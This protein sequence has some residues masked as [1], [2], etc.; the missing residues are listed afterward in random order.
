MKHRPIYILFSMF[1]LALAGGVTWVT[2]PFF[3]N[4]AYIIKSGSMQPAIFPGDVVVAQTG[5]DIPYQPHDIVTFT[6]ENN[7]RLFTTHRI[8]NKLV[9]NGITFYQTK[10][11]ANNQKDN[12]LVPEANIVGKVKFTIPFVGHI[13]AFARTKQG[14]PWFVL[15]PSFMVI[16]TES[17]NIVSELKKLKKK[18]IDFEMIGGF[19]QISLNETVQKVLSKTTNHSFQI[20]IPVLAV[21]VILAPKY[22]HS[23]FSDGGKS[24]INIFT[25]TSSGTVATVSGIA[26]HII[27]SEVQIA[28]GSGTGTTS[29]FIELYNPNNFGINLGPYKLV[30][31]PS[32]TSSANTT[33]KS[34]ATSN[35]IR[36]HGFFLWA[37]DSNDNHYASAI[38]ADVSTGE[39]IAED[40]SIALLAT[41]SATIDALSWSF[42]PNAL[43][44]GNRFPN[45]TP[46]ANQSIERKAL[47]TSDATS[48]A[49]GGTDQFKGN[50]Y[51]TDN[52]ATDFI[53]RPTALPQNSSSATESP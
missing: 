10:G 39:D 3:G 31:R 4:K 26:N 29:D 40:N 5:K 44:E 12:Q 53:L 34:F 13:L 9:K 45:A 7:V 19:E 49:V 1:F 38:S 16:L 41:G 33:I 2:L 47:A 6:S 42:N 22:S 48:M 23:F 52:N 32:G 20:L 14:F 35:I 51:D 18:F 36:P 15:F 21:S 8:E 11:D 30:K 17:R 46:S 25:A 24:N 28:T 50:G 43:Q 37:H 27:I